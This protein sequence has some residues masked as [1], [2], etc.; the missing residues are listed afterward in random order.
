M[1]KLSAAAPADA[2]TETTDDSR[3]CPD[4]SWPTT[5]TGN[6]GD[7]LRGVG[8]I[9]IDATTSITS[10]VEAMHGGIKRPLRKGSPDALRGGIAGLVYSSVRGITRGVG[11]GIDSA[12]VAVT[13]A[14]RRL[15]CAV[16][17]AS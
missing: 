12:A 5:A 8:K 2:P 11:F 1:S 9:A 3:H 10:L 14:A 15:M 13:R 6:V 4:P 7:D 16:G 17:T